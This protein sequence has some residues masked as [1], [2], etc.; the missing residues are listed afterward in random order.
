VKFQFEPKTTILGEGVRFG[1]NVTT[2]FYVFGNAR[3][4]LFKALKP[5]LKPI[6]NG[7]PG[8]GYTAVAFANRQRLFT[9]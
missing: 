3:K 1:L 4:P 6:R 2:T 5:L 7:F 8:V 9:F